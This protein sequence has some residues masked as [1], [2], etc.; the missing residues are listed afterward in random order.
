[1]KTGINLATIFLIVILSACTN[2]KDVNPI[3]GKWVDKQNNSV[4]FEFTENGRFDIKNSVNH[5]SILHGTYTYSTYTQNG[6]TKIKYTQTVNGKVVFTRHEVYKLEKD[7]LKFETKAYSS[8]GSK[9]WFIS[10]Y[11]MN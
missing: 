1:M 8:R 7:V 10:Y 2:D 9:S 6:K 11:R 3:V 5:K 4:Y